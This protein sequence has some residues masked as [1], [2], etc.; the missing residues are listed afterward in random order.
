MSNWEDSLDNWITEETERQSRR[1]RIIP[2]ATDRI[3][4]ESPTRALQAMENIS[5]FVGLHPEYPMVLGAGMTQNE[6]TLSFESPVDLPEPFMPL[7]EGDEVETWRISC[8]ET[9]ELPM[10]RDYGAQT[11]ALTA[12][13]HLTDEGT[14]LRMMTNTVGTKILGMAGQAEFKRSLM[15]GQV[16]EQATEPW[17]ADHRIFL[18]GFGELAR[19]LI[20]Y[21]QPYHS[22]FHE[23]EDLTQI[24][25]EDLGQ[26]QATIYVMGA[27]EATLGKFFA[28]NTGH[29]GLVTDAVV[30]ETSLYICETDSAVAELETG[31]QGVGVQR[32]MPNRITEDDPRYLA[33][34][35]AYEAS[36][37]E[38]EEEEVTTPEDILGGVPEG[39]TDPTET[40]EVESEPSQETPSFTDGDLDAFL[41][42]A[43][44]ESR[45]Q[46]IETR[47]DFDPQ[48]ETRAD[49]HQV[50]GHEAIDT[51]DRAASAFTPTHDLTLLGEPAVRTPGMPLS[52]QAAEAVAFVT[53]NGAEATAAEVS[54]ALWP[55]DD[56]EGNTARTRRSRLVKKINL[57]DNE[58]ITVSDAWRIKRLRTDYEEVT[59]MLNT[60]AISDDALID[61]AGYIT[62]PLKGCHAWADEHREQMRS[63]LNDALESATAGVPN[64]SSEAR[65]AVEAAKARLG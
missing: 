11:Q 25:T 35:R 41:R 22:G 55:T 21:L 24:T 47:N 56:A 40:A 36:I 26:S 51:E 37:Q 2:S 44:A 17:G 33:M 58:I 46:D 43:V 4:G 9:T 30:D 27:D 14:V 31:Y 54:R 63:D 52:G 49:D 20:Q 60:P 32:F 6:I 57:S 18:V 7:D 61:I 23:A 8:P 62:D 65:A 50:V 59:A 5:K 13:G 39:S 45:E 34:M 53:L 10:G 15:I 28:I 19:P 12:F 64:R 38:P 3:V 1:E 48:R 16:M 29:V 42:A